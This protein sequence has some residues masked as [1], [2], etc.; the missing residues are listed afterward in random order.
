MDLGLTPK[1]GGVFFLTKLLGKPQAIDL[2]LNVREF[3]ASEAK[4]LGIVDEVV[5]SEE[6]EQAAVQAVKRFEIIP[7]RTLAG[8]KRLMSFDSDELARFLE[9]ENRELMKIIDSPG[10]RKDLGQC[11][12]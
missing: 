7:G 2:L 9:L 12:E 3:T 4:S 10:F 6:I 1:G 5:G 11:Q 8:I